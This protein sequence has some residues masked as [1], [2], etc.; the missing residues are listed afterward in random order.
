LIRT[1]GELNLA[2]MRVLLCDADG[3]LYPSEEPAFVASA[4][5]TNAFLAAY[6][7]PVRFTAEDL[8][9]ATTGRNFR[10]TAVDLCVRYG[11]AL[12][13]A[14]ADLHPGAVVA[15]AA[16]TDGRPVLT[17]QDLEAWVAEERRQVTAHLG[18]LLRP[19][20]GVLGPL[21]ALRPRLTLAAV[22]SS[23]MSRL[24]ACFAATGLTPLIPSAY[25]YSAEDSL[26]VPTSKPDPAVYLLAGRLLG[27]RGGQ[28]L[29]VEDSVPG[30][31]AAVAAGFPTVGNVMFVPEGERRT[32][33]EAL[34][35]TGVRAIVDSWHDLADLVGS[36][37]EG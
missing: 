5:V 16:G 24:D 37:P 28:G 8:R 11:V 25:R 27:C 23:A 3:N 30:A 15:S 12:H 35:R 33:V 7:A 18:Q 20:P 34:R 32:R 17:P 29:A 13:P 14:L 19:D 36:V 2:E 31:Q 26:P 22:S 10:T 9:L 4:E 21:G 6:D 1:F